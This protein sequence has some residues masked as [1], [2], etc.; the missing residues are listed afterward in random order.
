MKEQEFRGDVMSYKEIDRRLSIRGFIIDERFVIPTTYGCFI[1]LTNNNDSWISIKLTKSII[2]NLYTNGNSQPDIDIYKARQ[3]W[4][5]RMNL[6]ITK[7]D[8]L[9][10]LIDK[11]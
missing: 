11:I 3:I 7:T 2:Y 9:E 1:H 5:D 4:N 6:L 10:K 8:N